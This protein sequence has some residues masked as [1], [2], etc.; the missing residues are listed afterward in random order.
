MI[1]QVDNQFVISS[2]GSWVP[3]VYDSERTARYAFRFEDRDLTALQRSQGI[4]GVITFEMLQKLRRSKVLD[5]LTA[6][7]QEEGMGY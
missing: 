3:G 2:G 7:A 1:H 5:E 6:Q 4:G